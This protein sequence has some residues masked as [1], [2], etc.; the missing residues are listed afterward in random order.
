M[1]RGGGLRLALPVGKD[2]RP[3]LSRADLALCDPPR[4]SG[5]R[6]RYFC[7]IHGGDH[8][9]SLSVD[10][11]TGK[12]RCHTCQASGTLRE[13]WSG[14]DSSPRP[15]RVLSMEDIGRR[16]LAARSRVEA[17][18]LARFAT[19]LPADAVALLARLDAMSKA[20]RDPDCPGAV[21]LRRRGLDPVRAAELGAGYAPPNLWPGDR[22]RKAGRVVF[23]LADP[24]SGR[25]VSAA[26]R[27]CLDADPAWSEAQRETF[28]VIKQRKLPG[29]PAGIWPYESL[30]QARALGRPLIVV[31]GS[32]DA[33]ALLQ[34]ANEHLDAVALIGTAGAVLP[35]AAVQNIPGLVLAFDQDGAGAKGAR[36]LRA[37]MALAGVPVETMPADWLGDVDA[38]DPADLLDDRKVADHALAAE[39]YR[40]A[41]AALAAACQR[42]RS[43]SWDDGEAQRALDG[44]FRRCAEASQTVPQPWP[45]LDTSAV[46]AAYEAR[47]WPALVRAVAHAERAF[48]EA[49]H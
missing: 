29:C 49:L 6:E 39:R 14:A 44:L 36:V 45:E 12:Y 25:L 23:P 5:G 13:Y 48:L 31:E 42:L 18:R 11:E 46:E 22:H 26:G 19:A 32:T 37:D 15:I 33:L 3:I 28:N 40:Y 1:N 9:R 8:Q 20:L 2:G 17:D 38:K 10:P 30:V 43:R 21:Y 35:A 24:C 47:D 34:A 16:E 41:L 27:L 7:P 4:V